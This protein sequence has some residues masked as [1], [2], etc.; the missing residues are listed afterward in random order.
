MK[1]DDAALVDSHVYGMTC[2]PSFCNG[3]NDSFSFDPGGRDGKML[4]VDWVTCIWPFDPGGY[5]RTLTC[6]C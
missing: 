5:L 2:M 4:I 6:C 3:C 1:G